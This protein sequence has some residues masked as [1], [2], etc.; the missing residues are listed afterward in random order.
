MYVT[1][2]NFRIVVVLFYRRV[3][4]NV[5]LIPKNI[6]I[7]NEALNF[8]SFLEISLLKL[9]ANAYVINFSSMSC[10]N[11]LLCCVDND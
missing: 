8:T 1:Y 4:I 11:W 10:E 2:Q 5:V 7:L 6:W 3:L 9:R